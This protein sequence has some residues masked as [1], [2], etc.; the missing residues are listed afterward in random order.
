MNKIKHFEDLEIWRQARHLTATAYRLT[1]RGILQK[2]WS[3]SDQLKR[4]AISIMANIAEGFE[5]D[6][7]SEFRHFLY[8]AKASCGEFRSHLVIAHDLGYMPEDQ[9]LKLREQAIVLSRRIAALIASLNQSGM[10]GRKFA[11]QPTSQPRH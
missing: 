6:G 7:N 3:L 11:R 5:R 8:I 1:S 2:E 10:K 9:Y 4:S